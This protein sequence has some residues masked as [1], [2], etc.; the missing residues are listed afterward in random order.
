MILVDSDVIIWNWRGNDKAATSLAAIHEMSVSAVTYMELVQGMRNQ[1]EW[2]N[3]QADLKLWQAS[4][5]PITETISA[6]AV[7]LVETHFRSHHVQLADALIAATALEHRVPLLT[8]NVKHFKA[9]KG[10]KI[11][12]FTVN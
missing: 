3:L 5:L 8:G 12:P 1:R 7:K 4:V 9:I 10:L 6:R 2:K 11:K